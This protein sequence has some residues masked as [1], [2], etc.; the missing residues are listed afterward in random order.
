ML[1]IG[2]ANKFFTLWDVQIENNYREI[3]GQHRPTG[4]TTS[5]FYLQNLSIDEGKAKIKFTER[6]GIENPSVDEDLKGKTINFK[7]QQPKCPY[8]D[9]EFNFGKYEGDVIEECTDVDYLNWAYSDGW[10]KGERVEHAEKALKNNGQVRNL[11]DDGFC[12][13]EVLKEQKAA[14]KVQDFNASLIGGFHLEDGAKVELDLIVHDIGGFSGSYG[15]VN[16]YIFILD[17]NKKVKYQGA[18]E[19]DLEIGMKIAVKATV[20][21]NS[22]YSSYNEENVEETK[23]LRMKIK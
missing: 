23:L 19:F 7:T 11:Y 16:T 15:Y 18:K 1:Q 17:G 10:F 8:L 6:T 20:K 12:T 5:F 21:H 2:F 3:N 9:T 14:K 13:P 4:T 22:F